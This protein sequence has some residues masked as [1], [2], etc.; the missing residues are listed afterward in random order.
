MSVLSTTT[1]AGQ[2]T[3]HPD[4]TPEEALAFALQFWGQPQLS[5]QSHSVIAQFANTCLPTT[6]A[7]WQKSPYKAMR[8]NALRMLIAITPDM[9]VS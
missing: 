8:Q 4:E 7:S 5:A 6:L 3:N 1:D 2:P 9:Q